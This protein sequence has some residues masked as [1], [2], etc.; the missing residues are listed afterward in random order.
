MEPE[1]ELTAPEISDL[2]EQ[3]VAAGLETRLGALDELE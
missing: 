2:Y 3:A 1:L